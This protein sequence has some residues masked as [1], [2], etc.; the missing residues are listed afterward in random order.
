MNNRIKQT[1]LEMLRMGSDPNDILDML[2]MATADLGD[3]IDYKN[4]KSTGYL[5]YY[6]AIKDSDFRP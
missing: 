2:S 6:L 5:E 4:D 1:V 3:A